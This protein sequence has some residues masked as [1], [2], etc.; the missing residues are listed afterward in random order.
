MWMSAATRWYSCCGARCNVLGV[1]V[2][3]RAVM[4]TKKWDALNVTPGHLDVVMAL[5]EA[6]ATGSQMLETRITKKEV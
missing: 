2:A 6:A 3:I 5:L 4:K 1:G